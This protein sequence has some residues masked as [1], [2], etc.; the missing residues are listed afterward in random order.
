MYVCT[1]VCAHVR[2]HMYVMFPHT[3]AHVCE[4]TYMYVHTPLCPYV[5][6]SMYVGTHLCVHACKHS[7]MYVCTYLCVRVQ[8]HEYVCAHLRM[9]EHMCMYVCTH[10]CDVCFPAV[11]L[12]SRTWQVWAEGLLTL[13][14]SSGVAFTVGS[15]CLLVRVKGSGCPLLS[16]LPQAS[17]PLT[18]VVCAC[19]HDGLETVVG[20]SSRGCL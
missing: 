2:A 11:T 16:Q 14:G 15:R 8:S 17:S 10:L 3:S 6:T 18:L 19:C 9:C 7:C 5:S 4:H 1:S 12:Q 13:Y 20:P